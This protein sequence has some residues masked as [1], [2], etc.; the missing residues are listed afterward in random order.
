MRISMI[1]INHV[2]SKLGYQF[3]RIN[4]KRK[5]DGELEFWKNSIALYIKWYL[6]EIDELY[7]ETHPSAAQKIKGFNLTDSA[8]LTW[9][10]IHQEAKYLQDLA[11]PR[12]S[13]SGMRLLDIGS[14]PIPSAR[15][16]DNCALYCLDPLLPSYLAIGFPI[17][18]YERVKFVHAC[19][20]DIPFPNNYF[21][22]IISVN[23]LDHVD[24]FEKT[25]LEIRRV[26]KPGGKIRFHLHYHAPTK[27]E[28]IELSDSKIIDSFGW[29]PN[30]KK[31]SESKKKHGTELQQGEGIYTLWSNF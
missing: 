2:L 30:F 1:K 16:F 6:G 12:E 29:C 26:L 27:L 9:G 17:H 13:F 23:A 15:A 5:N 14:G 10:K 11:L 31:I 20:E 7:G 25:T 28:P 8:I 22:A 4:V 21:D 3:V 24:N 19:S 18:Y